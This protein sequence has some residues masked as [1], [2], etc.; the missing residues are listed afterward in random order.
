MN[1]GGAKSGVMNKDRIA[2]RYDEVRRG[3]FAVLPEGSLKPSEYAFLYILASGSG[4]G[5][6]SGGAMAH[7]CF[8]FLSAK[9]A[10]RPRLPP[11]A[12]LL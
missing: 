3:G 6:N 4:L 10:Y 8:I 5:I 12:S 2:F 7:G 1:I 9:G 11:I